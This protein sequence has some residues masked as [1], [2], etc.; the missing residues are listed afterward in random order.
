M[1]D[2]LVPIGTATRLPSGSPAPGVARTIAR[3]CRVL[4]ILII[5]ALAGCDG[6]TAPQGSTTGRVAGE[7]TVEHHDVTGGHDHDHGD[8]HGEDAGEGGHHEHGDDVDEG[9]HRGHGDDADEGGHRGH[10]DEPT[11][12]VTIARE[13]A[14]ESGIRVAPAAP[15]RIRN[16]QLVQGLLVP[17]EGRSARVVARFPG[18]VRAVRVQTGDTVRAG[19]V[20]AVVESN[21]S[22]SNYTVTAPVSGTVLSRNVAVG[23]LAGNAPMFEI[24]DLSRLWVDLHLFGADGERI[25]AGLPVRVERLSDG[26]QAQTVIDRV[27]PGSATASQSTVARATLANDDGR[28]R[29]G[30]AVRARVTL[31]ERDA[32]IVVPSGALQRLDG[33]DVVFVRVPPGTNADGV[34]GAGGASGANDAVAAAGAAGAG[35][36]AGANRVAVA[37]TVATHVDAERYE[38]RVVQLGARDGEHVEVLAGLLPG[39]AVVVAQSYLVKAELGKAGLAHEH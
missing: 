18:P 8:E 24:A 28:W 1:I 13:V 39:E 33:R 31:A 34:A 37:G 30:A 22:L 32:E 38:A 7:R 10:G 23:D 16:D 4:S 20:L 11:D 15:G 19:Q 6:P 3:A 12:H 36:A 27:L 26:E 21:L 5:A 2:R 17:V 14:D 35:A 9:G 25:A 29:P